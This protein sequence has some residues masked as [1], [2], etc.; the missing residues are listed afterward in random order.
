MVVLIALMY[1]PYPIHVHEAALRH[2]MVQNERRTT[3]KVPNTFLEGE[4]LRTHLRFR[5]RERVGLTCCALNCLMS[6][7]ETN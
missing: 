6:N 7:M 2:Q 1:D 5:E 4:V 3:R